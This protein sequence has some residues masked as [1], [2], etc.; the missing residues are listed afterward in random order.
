VDEPVSTW[1]PEY[2]IDPARKGIKLRH[3]L[4]HTSG[5]LTTQGSHDIY[6]QKNFVKFALESPVVTPPGE[7]FKY[8][9][10]AIN[11]ASGIVGKVTG[12]PMDELLA[13]NLFKPLEITDYR[14]RHDRAGN[15]WAMDGLEMTASD[16]VKIG[17]VLAEGGKWKGKQIISEK[18]LAVATEASLVSLDRNGAY[19]L[20]IFVLE[21]DARLAIPSATVD[22]LE[23]AGLSSSITAK[24]R[25]LADKEYKGSKELGA[26]LKQSLTLAELESVSS[27]AARQM[28]PVYRNLGGRKLLA[29]S[30]EIGEYLLAMPGP[31]V[32]VART[33]DEKRGRAGDFSFGSI[34]RRVLDLA[35]AEPR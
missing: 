18:W 2:A 27:V 32:A 7:E 6:P 26:A 10:R 3:V 30:G 34:Y 28:I 14:F 21:P 25:T 12:K 16:L 22:A 19:G 31:G 9:N 20:G 23:K 35:P 17:S 5:I 4:Q 11:I 1:Y 8:N 24:L 13:A 33:I 29:H 15:T